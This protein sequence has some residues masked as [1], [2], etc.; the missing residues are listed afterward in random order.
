MKRELQNELIIAGARARLVDLE[1]QRLEIL[2]AFPQL[3]P[4][5]VERKLQKKRTQSDD[6]QRAKILA[7]A[8]ENGVAK[9]AEKFDVFTSA[10]YRWM[11]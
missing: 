6:G 5:Q 4:A 7:Y 10:I 11:P 1:K 2:Q 3:N 8:R 9:A